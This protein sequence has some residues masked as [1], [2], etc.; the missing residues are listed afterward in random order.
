MEGGKGVKR[1]LKC[2]TALSYFDQ[3]MICSQLKSF[4]VKDATEE[5][6]AVIATDE[7][8]HY[9]SALGYRKQQYA[10]GESLSFSVSLIY[11]FL[12]LS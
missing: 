5:C 8:G 2:T 12:L 4:D 7:M 3:N 6:W 11:L 9:W 1:T 10:L